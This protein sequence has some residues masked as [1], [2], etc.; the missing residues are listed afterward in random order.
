MVNTRFGMAVVLVAATFTLSSCASGDTVV[1]VNYSFDTTASDVQGDVTSLHIRI[2]AQ[3]GGQST[4]VF[5]LTHDDAGAI[6][7]ATYTRIVVNGMSGPAE[8]SV[9]AKDGSGST[10]LAG[11]VNIDIVEHYGSVAYVKLAT[12]AGAPRRFWRPKRKR[13]Q[14]QQRQWSRG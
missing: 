1:S 14:Q 6:T 5:N 4:A 13:R 2:S 7:S 10:L 8:V 12:R 11:K 9:E 3:S